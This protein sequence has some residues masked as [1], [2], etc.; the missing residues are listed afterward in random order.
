MNKDVVFGIY[1]NN[2][3][4]KVDGSTLGQALEFDGGT[5]GALSNPIVINL[6]VPTGVTAPAIDEA[7]RFPY[8]K[9]M[10]GTW[11]LF[12]KKEDDGSEYTPMK[13]AELMTE[14]TPVWDRGQMGNAI[15]FEDQ[16]LT[17]TGETEGRVI[18]KIMGTKGEI[19]A[20]M[21]GNHIEVFNFE[22]REPYKYDVNT[23]VTGEM[24]TG[25]HGGG[26]TG[27][28][29]ALRELLRGNRSKSVCEIGES[30][31]NHMISFAAEESRLTG[32]V[33]D[34]AEFEARFN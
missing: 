22:K 12:Y 28:I 24:I 2:L 10:T 7:V 25:G 11:T 33:I 8:S 31:D 26:D 16:K 27:I 23:A 6:D 30:C 21:G 9:D 1:Y 5:H 15:S 14:L 13:Q 32:K 17:V 19:D 20:K 4:F 18:L 3:L 29:Y 34:M